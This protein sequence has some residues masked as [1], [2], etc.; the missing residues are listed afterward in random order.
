MAYPAVYELIQII[1]TGVGN[2]FADAGNYVD[3]LYIYGSVSLAYVHNNYTPYIW[4]SKIL[5]IVIVILSIRRTFSYLRLLKSLS[6]IVTMLQRVIWELRVFL[7]FYVILILLF[8]MM[9]GVLGLGNPNIPGGF[10]EEYFDFTTKTLKN[11]SP[12]SEYQKVGLLLGNFIQTVRLSMGDFSAIDA[13]DSLNTNE[14]LLFWFI[15]AVTV[16]IT[17]I[18]F[19]NFI[20]AEAS[21]VYTKV[22]E[23]LQEYIQ[24]Q[25][26]EL[27][28]EAEELLPSICFGNE[29]N[30]PKYILIR[31]KET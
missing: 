4:Y 30:F 2:Y 18:I 26:A 9:Y 8:S 24:Q 20:V 14:N 6:P 17:C 7:S 13:A 25:R 23:Q 21:A 19:L 1:M 28:G 22:S 12:G 3:I 27:T 29:S 5:I 31:Q 11:N 10:R 15:W 16:V